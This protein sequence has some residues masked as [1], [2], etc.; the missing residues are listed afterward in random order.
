MGGKIHGKVSASILFGAADPKEGQTFEA[1][2]DNGKSEGISED[3]RLPCDLITWFAT[4]ISVEDSSDGH[5]HSPQ[6]FI[7]NKC[8]IPL[9]RRR[10]QVPTQM[11]NIKLISRLAPNAA[12]A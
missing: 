6:P 11:S 7:P 8:L 12:Q 5:S 9:Y 1:R 3:Q 4:P 2:K 10:H